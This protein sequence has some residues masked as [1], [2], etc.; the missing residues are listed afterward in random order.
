MS[1][2]LFDALEVYC[3]LLR[4]RAH[5]LSGEAGVAEDA[6]GGLHR[7][8]EAPAGPGQALSQEGQGGG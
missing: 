1:L 7:D 5:L 2:V 3:W 6:D 4:P 8:E